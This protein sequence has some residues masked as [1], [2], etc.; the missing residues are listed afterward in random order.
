MITLELNSSQVAGDIG[1]MGYSVCPRWACED[2]VCTL[3]I[4]RLYLWCLPVVPVWVFSF[5]SSE[6]SFPILLP[7]SHSRGQ[8]PDRELNQISLDDYGKN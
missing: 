3:S 8:L 7:Q 5:P 1:H 6:T 4:D 2:G